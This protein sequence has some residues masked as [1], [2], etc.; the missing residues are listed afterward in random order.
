M[1]GAAGRKTRY[2]PSP[3][4]LLHLGHA[5]T[6]LAIHL[7]ARSSDARIAMRIE[8]LD[9]P[10]IRPGA[11]DAILRTHDYLGLDFD[12]GPT[13]QSDRGEAYHDALE[14]LGARTYPCTC[15]RREIESIASAPHGEDGPLYPGT[16][17]EGPTH[18]ERPAAIRF[19]ME[20][21][22]AFDDLLAGRITDL[23]AGDFV[24][25]RADGVYAYQLAVVVDDAA[26]GITDVIRG[27]DLLA[28]TPRQLALIDALGLPRPTYAHLPLVRR[29]DGERLAKRTGAIGVLD[30]ADAGIPRETMLGVL[31]YSLGLVATPTPT[32]LAELVAAFRWSRIA[33]RDDDLDALLRTS[34]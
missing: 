1:N 2:A 29:A 24:L 5:R 12:E 32:T 13:F 28:S 25:R 17:R 7:H 34:R 19:R 18:P 23:G 26:A 16:C 27:A 33:P 15:S 9:G 10:R 6:H 30:Y 14:R 8:D 21:P 20:T 31:A 22:P 3:T 4:G 11:T